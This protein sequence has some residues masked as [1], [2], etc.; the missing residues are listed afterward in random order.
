MHL[1]LDPPFKTKSMSVYDFKLERNNNLVRTVIAF[2]RMPSAHSYAEKLEDTDDASWLRTG[3]GQIQVPTHVQ[4]PCDIRYRMR[5]SGSKSRIRTYVPNTTHV[6]IKFLL[7]TPVLHPNDMEE[8]RGVCRRDATQ[9]YRLQTYVC[10][11]DDQDKDIVHWFVL[12]VSNIFLDDVVPYASLSDVWCM[13]DTEESHLLTRDYPDRTKDRKRIACAQF[14]R[15]VRAGSSSAS[16][17]LCLNAACC[18]YGCFL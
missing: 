11:Q 8:I 17:T 10:Q 13:Y 18:Q 15:L 7:L 16:W 2:P 3:G 4:D 14:H 1:R 5:G 12:Q 6:M 9:V